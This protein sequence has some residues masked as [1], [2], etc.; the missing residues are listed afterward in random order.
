MSRSGFLMER[1]FPMTSARDGAM[2]LGGTSSTS[3]HLLE[4]WASWNSALR[5]RLFR[6]SRIGC[7]LPFITCALCFCAL[8]RVSPLA[9]ADGP[10]ISTNASPART[11]DD[12]EF[13]IGPIYANA[14]ELTVN[15][16]VPRG[17]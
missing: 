5:N 14:P 8:L 9:A 6:E 15:D 4:V 16:G 3:P 11:K 1:I 17:I 7:A 2:N 10:A 13:T 12:I